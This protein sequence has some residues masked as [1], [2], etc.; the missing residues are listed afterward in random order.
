MAAMTQG[1]TPSGNT[2]VGITP[3]GN[4]LW[5]QYQSVVAA[6]PDRPA[7]VDQ[8]RTSMTHGEL[9]AEAE[10]T[11]AVLHQRGMRAGDHLGVFLPNRA[12]W[13]VLA[14][15]AA[16]IGVG[17]L[18]LNTRFREA[19]LNHLLG[20][21]KVDT[22]VVADDFLGIDGPAL[23]A[24][25]DRS[26]DVIVDRGR[27]LSSDLVM[28]GADHPGMGSFNEAVGP[29][30][31]LMGFTTSGTTG[32]PK[33]AMHSQAQT[34]SHLTAV[35]DAFALDDN[36]VSLVPLPFCGAFGYTA[37][38]AT[39]LAGGMVVLHETWDP[40]A[41]AA[42]IA[43]H[44]VTMC[45][46][47]DDMLLALVASERFTAPTTWS[48]G[49]FADFTNAGSDAVAAVA[50]ATGGSTKLTGLYGSSEG[51]ALMSCWERDL[52]QELRSRNG[53]HLVSTDMSV[54]CCDP[55]TGQV[56]GHDKP[57][58]LQFRGPN[59]ISSYLNNP[60]ATAKAFTTD[61]WYRSGDLGHTVEPDANGREG[62][63]FLA[64]LGDTLRL[65]GFLCDPAEIEKH[66]EG[67]PAVALAQVVGVKQ[68]SIG[69]VAVA[70]VRL[71]AETETGVDVLDPANAEAVLADHCRSGLANYKRPERVVV[72]DEFPVTDGPNGVKIRKV[73]LRTHAEALLADSPG[74]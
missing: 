3:S 31:P 52:P 13:A 4:T 62:F 59:L 69:D 18:G 71:E 68:P 74:N 25:L 35:C 47:S 33:V 20:V 63:V 21:A 60:E 53:G 61:G 58:E 66:L 8:H 22:V 50:S 51:F 32:F 54:R 57:G 49:G 24:G 28:D 44:G 2:P 65:R 27:P 39:L 5:E 70:F 11:A 64:R 12:S 26:V 30:S 55:E 43:E 16:R 29:Q 9:F 46:A 67:H 38:M 48:G 1:S 40:D 23:M 10:A 45:S 41:A 17:V 73:D 14:L 6:F 34:L 36:M 42:A 72:V 37:G 7:V 56:L 15:A 19:E